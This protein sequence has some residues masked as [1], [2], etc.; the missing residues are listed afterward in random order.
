MFNIH[1]NPIGIVHIVTE[2]SRKSKEK[3]LCSY[4]NIAHLFSFDW[5]K[6]QWMFW[7]NNDYFGENQNEFLFFEEK[8]LWFQ[9]M[10]TQ[11]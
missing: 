6:C 9:L 8:K 4:L 11:W 7:I 3:L 1:V 5:K 2:T 10:S